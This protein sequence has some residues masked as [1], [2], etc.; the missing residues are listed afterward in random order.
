MVDLYE[1]LSSAGGMLAEG[2]KIV[3]GKNEVNKYQKMSTDEKYRG[4]LVSMRFMLVFR[5]LL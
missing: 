4:K 5:S 3:N 2:S 1:R